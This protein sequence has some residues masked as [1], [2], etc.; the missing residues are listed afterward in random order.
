[1]RCWSLNYPE[2]EGR[3]GRTPGLSVLFCEIPDR[4]VY[5]VTASEMMHVLC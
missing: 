2:A 3:V 1:M 5:E 4:F